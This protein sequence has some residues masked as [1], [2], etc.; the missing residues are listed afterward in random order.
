MDPDYVRKDTTSGTTYLAIAI[1]NSLMRLR[2]RR[3]A[4][5]IHHGR[6]T[7]A[8]LQHFCG[9]S[10]RDGV[11]AAGRIRA[12]GHLFR[13]ITAH[14]KVSQTT[15]SR[16]TIADPT[17]ATNACWQWPYVRPSITSMANV[18]ALPQSAN[19]SSYFM[20]APHPQSTPQKSPSRQIGLCKALNSAEIPL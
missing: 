20:A 12:V 9:R 14:F 1:G 4:R 11:F 18:K 17:A 6:N 19:P 15:K 10:W 7:E 5:P 16:H 2:N 3:A 13:L 8:S